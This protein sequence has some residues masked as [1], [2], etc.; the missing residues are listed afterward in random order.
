MAKTVEISELTEKQASWLKTMLFDESRKSSE[1]ADKH[2]KLSVN[3]PPL[4]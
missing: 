1:S 2:H 3:Y 4:K